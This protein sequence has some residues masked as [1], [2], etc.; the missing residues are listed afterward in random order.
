M[1]SQ[2]LCY[3]LLTY[4]AQGRSAMDLLDWLAAR[5]GL[6]RG[7][8]SNGYLWIWVPRNHEVAMLNIWPQILERH[9]DQDL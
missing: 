4:R 5:G 9:I 6:S 3:R 2:L 7:D 1:A 8:L